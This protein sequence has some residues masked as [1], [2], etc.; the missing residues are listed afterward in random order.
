MLSRKK[1]IGFRQ[2]CHVWQLETNKDI[3]SATD[4]CTKPGE[5]HDTLSWGGNNSSVKH[6][7]LNE[8]A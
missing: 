7:P 4:I 8:K 3:E 2:C 5:K 1:G 6:T